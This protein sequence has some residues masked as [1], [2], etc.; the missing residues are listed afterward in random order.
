MSGRDS[1]LTSNIEN[2]ES[3]HAAHLN[4]ISC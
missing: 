1:S 3:E 4:R 2:P